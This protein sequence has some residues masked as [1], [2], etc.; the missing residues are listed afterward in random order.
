[1]TS[2]GAAAAK[3]AP[4]PNVNV[5]VLMLGGHGSKNE[6]SERLSRSGTDAEI[7]AQIGP[8]ELNIYSPLGVIRDGVESAPLLEKERAVYTNTSLAPS[9]A[10][11][12]VCWNKCDPRILLEIMAK[13]LQL[14]DN[15]A[16]VKYKDPD[17]RIQQG[18]TENKIFWGKPMGEQIRHLK[19]GATREMPTR[20]AAGDE[21]H[22]PFGLTLLSLCN[23]DGFPISDGTVNTTIA[24]F[25]LGN[26]C[27]KL[28]LAEFTKKK[29]LLKKLQGKNSIVIDVVE[30]FAQ[31]A[32]KVVKTHWA[33]LNLLS[34]RNSGEIN[35][36]I[37]QIASEAQA[38]IDKAQIDGDSAN[39][40]DIW[41]VNKRD[42]VILYLNEVQ[43]TKES[44]LTKIVVI[45]KYILPPNTRIDIVDQTC[46]GYYTKQAPWKA[47]TPAVFDSM[48]EYPDSALSASSALSGSSG[49]SESDDEIDAEINAEI[50]AE[51]S[52]RDNLLEKLWSGWEGVTSFVSSAVSS[53]VSTAGAGARSMPYGGA[54]A[55][56]KR[57]ANGGSRK[58]RKRTTV[59]RKKITRKTKKRIFKRKSQK[60]NRRK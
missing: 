19:K 25:M 34:S 30:P 42:L 53:A 33:D 18:I 36:A 24:G 38:R 35:R 29:E 22:F 3:H 17:K 4:G 8:L 54:R 40:H 16:G 31:S 45:C 26:N 49:S 15:I 14:L 2:T 46:S 27:S 59:R 51:K 7:S 5:A 41:L 57:R 9:V 43:V 10:C 44:E 37:A 56:N 58:S 6:G 28:R 48:G 20:V 21:I 55:D 32:T 12:L 39:E 11:S 60:R 52:W 50:E 47:V 23:K 1:M 13:E